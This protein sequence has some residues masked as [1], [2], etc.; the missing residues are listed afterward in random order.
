MNMTKRADIIA[1][2]LEEKAVLLIEVK[3]ASIAVQHG[4]MQLA[5]YLRLMPAVVPYAMLVNTQEMRVYRW[6]GQRLDGPVVT[7]E[8]ARA[9]TPYEPDFEQKP[10][11][12]YYLIGL[13]EAWLRDIAYHWKSSIPPYFEAMSNIGLAE[14]LAGG[15]TRS[16]VSLDGVMSHDFVR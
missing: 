13:V 16:Q 4:E 15:T 8:T 7:L 12:E 10:I 3:K 9:L 5:E 6:D 11:Y 14:Q 1:F 2:D